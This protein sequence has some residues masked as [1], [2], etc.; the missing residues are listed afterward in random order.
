MTDANGFLNS[1]DL[2]LR[3]R[4]QKT[5]RP[6]RQA[7]APGLAIHPRHTLPLLLYLD[8]FRTNVNRK[9][10]KKYRQSSPLHKRL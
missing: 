6:Q 5:N 3:T 7:N 8:C 10:E 9:S 1:A 2:K 4:T